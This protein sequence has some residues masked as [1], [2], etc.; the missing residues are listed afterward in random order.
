MHR[1]TFMGRDISKTITVSMKIKYSIL[2]R[3]ALS[4]KSTIAGFAEYISQMNILSTRY[5]EREGGIG[6]R[7][8]GLWRWVGIGL[9]DYF[10]SSWC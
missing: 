7:K 1:S 8:G 10:T 6:G 2:T 9:N 5:K 4:V 3:P